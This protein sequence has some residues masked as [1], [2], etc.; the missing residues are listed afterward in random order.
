MNRDLELKLEDVG[1]RDVGAEDGVGEDLLEV[2][3]EDGVGEGLLDV[4]LRVRKFE[5][6]GVRL[7][8]PGGWFLEPHG[9]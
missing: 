1:P 7:E 8:V 5:A 2:G 6:G 3:A 4:G 9:E